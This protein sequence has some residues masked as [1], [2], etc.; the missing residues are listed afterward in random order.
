ME[1]EWETDINREGKKVHEH[2]CIKK[3]SKQLSAN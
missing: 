2:V 3:K 1:V